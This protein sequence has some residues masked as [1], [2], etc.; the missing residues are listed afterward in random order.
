[1]KIIEVKAV[2]MDT[3]PTMFSIECS[4]CGVVGLEFEENTDQ[5]CLTHLEMHNVDTSAYRKQS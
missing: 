3:P 2:P 5:E 4:E 1:M